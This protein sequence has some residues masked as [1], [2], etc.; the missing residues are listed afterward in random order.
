VSHSGTP[1][2]VPGEL[3]VRE[4][5]EPE[6]VLVGPRVGVDYARPQ[7]RDAPYRFADAGSRALSHPRTLVPL[8]RW[9]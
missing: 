2:F 3:E 5:P 8:S 4:G 6:Q 9:R 1:L 7:D